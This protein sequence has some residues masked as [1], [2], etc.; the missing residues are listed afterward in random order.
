MQLKP[1][2][3]VIGA[4]ILG[5]FGIGAVFSAR[6]AFYAFSPAQPGSD[7][8]VILEVRKGQGPLEISRSLESSHAI[9]DS[10]SFALVGRLSRQWGKIKAGEYKVSP[11]MSPLEIFGVITSGVSI[12]HP[13]TIREG[14][15]MY[16]IAS[17]LEQKGLA[18]RAQ[19]LVLVRSPAL[20]QSLRIS[21]QSRPVA[22]LEGYLFPET[23]FFNKSMTAEEMIR[24]MV[25]RFFQAWGEPEAARAK[26]LGLSR[27]E[28]IT[29]ASMIE[30]ETGA[31]QERPMI[32]SVFYNRLKKHMRLQSDPT[33]IYGIW[34]KY[35]GNLHRSDLLTVNNYNT[36]AIT[37]LPA[38]PIGNPG[39]E[40]IKAALNP[41]ETNYLFF[42][43]HNDGT[44]QFSATLAEHN[45]AVSKFQL[46]PKAR[47]GKSWRDL[48]KEK[49]KPPIR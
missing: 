18:K 25:R 21:T 31:A 32:S 44:H 6:L 27:H 16:E 36:Y 11:G 29:L 22:T 14:E 15:N 10:E 46:D 23:Y 12:A 24:Q 38:G 20:L 1:K 39:R 48:G 34:E 33:T 7:A 30:K 42:V 35:R 26:V 47:A 8:A 49:A 2:R 19:F 17:D 43:S 40:S 45:S 28:I 4:A 13:I 9:H 37:A 5:A 41:V 3:L